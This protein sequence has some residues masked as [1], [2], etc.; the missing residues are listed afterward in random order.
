M[1]LA[2]LFLIGSLSLAYGHDPGLSTVTVKT[3]PGRLAAEATFAR[4]DIEALV[5]L[6]VNHDGKVSA[7]EWQ[8]AGPLL[9]P[10][11]RDT[12]VVRE[13]DGTTGM[14]EIGFQLAENDNFRVAGN[15]RA[16][17]AKVTLESPLLKQLPRG[18]RQFISVL[19]NQGTP[20]A[21]ALFTAENKA[22]DVNAETAEEPRHLQTATTFG[23][24]FLMGVEH[25]LTGYD[26]L[27]FL[28]GLL[29]AMS[30]FR[31]TLWMISCFTLAH[32]ATLA[33]AAFDLVRVPAH[34]VEP[35]IAATIIYVG[36]ENLLRLHNPTGRW[37]LALIFGLVHGLGFATDLKEKVA[38]M[39]DEKI[40]FP[41]V[42]F[43]LGVELGQMAI[44]SLVLPMIW[45]FR[46][47]PVVIRVMVPACS[48]V[49]IVAGAWWLLERTLLS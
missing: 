28:F 31:A 12:L 5:P 42:S 4:A 1:R 7:Q 16:E 32:S 38:G 25:I 34:I 41:L 19:N 26:H 27:I 33:L 23:G 3:L 43:N 15:V 22:L 47:E 10:L 36:L 13:N 21:E 9:E 39:V 35:L 24:F 49:V 30:Q 2:V 46:N 17:G 20:I 14:T 37:R 44:A 6:D 8:H 11:L 40:V 18:H 45:W 48:V 29:I